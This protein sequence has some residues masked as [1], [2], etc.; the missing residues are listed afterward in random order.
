M[1]YCYRG[2]HRFRTDPDESYRL[3]Y[4]E[5]AD[6]VVWNRMD[7]EASID[8]SPTGWDSE[9]VAYPS[10]YLHRGRKYLLYNGNGFGRS[11]IGQAVADA[12]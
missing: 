11:G 8:R 3:G 9:M 2:L 6:G 7:D 5:S 4:A 12:P 1:W 10:V